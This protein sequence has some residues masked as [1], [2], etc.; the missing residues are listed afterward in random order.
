MQIWQ[1][2]LFGAVQGFTEFLPVSS[3]GHLILAERWLNVNTDGGLFF[4][5]TL[6]IGTLVPV[7]IV[8]F[9]SIKELFKRPYNKFCYL[10][11]ATVPAAITGFLFQDYIEK[12]YK[13]GDLLS[14]IL[15]AVS[16]CVTAAEL[17][18]AEKISKNN[19]N[20]L[21]LSVKSSIIM[22]VFQGIA[23]I[24]GLSRSGTVITGG[25]VAR[26]DRNS[27]AEFAFLMSI[28]VILG[29]SAAS[30]IKVIK[31]GCVIEPLPIIFGVIT[32]AITGY[33][34]VN[35]TLKS[36]K[37]G[38]YKRFSLYLLILAAASVVTKALFG[39]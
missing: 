30:G 26:L 5:I 28:P 21:P 17:F 38:K 1:A 15:L 27:N 8:F 37:K 3:S 10:V 18:V 31:S 11:I 35:A 6:H 16:F 39:V 36:I 2:I 13:S 4:D 12:F 20:I 14:A 9:K 33:I 7:F 22:G 19:K 34:A 23:I 29:A 24:P 25:A 32:A